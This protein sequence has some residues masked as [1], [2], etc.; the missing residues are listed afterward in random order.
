MIHAKNI[1]FN[2]TNNLIGVFI[3]T[4]L[5]G[6]LVFVLFR[7]VAIELIAGCQDDV[8]QWIDCYKLMGEK[9]DP[10]W[11]QSLESKWN[12]ISNLKWYSTCNIFWANRNGFLILSRNDF[13]SKSVII[14]SYYYY[15]NLLIVMG[16]ITKWS[17]EFRSFKNWDDSRYIKKIVKVFENNSYPDLIST[18]KRLNGFRNNNKLIEMES[19]S[20]KP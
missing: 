14:L 1:Q 4:S 9:I 10:Q 18:R 7:S 16:S 5:W 13:Y 11:T 17:I 20:V 12:N 2:R 6:S 3:F 8:V 15:I 19:V